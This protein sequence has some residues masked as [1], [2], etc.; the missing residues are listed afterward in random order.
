MNSLI[1]F[2][3]GIPKFLLPLDD[4]RVSLIVELSR[5]VLMPF[6]L[7]L[8]TIQSSCGQM[9]SCGVS[10]IYVGASNDTAKYALHF[11]IVCLYDINTNLL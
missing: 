10:R 1:C 8:N 4:R 7:P 2:L 9:L 3:G 11:V 5:K 6:C